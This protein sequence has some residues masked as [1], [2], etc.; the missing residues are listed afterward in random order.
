MSAQKWDAE[1]YEARH[2]F[3]WQYGAGLIDL[4]APKPGE[5]ILDVGCGTG[6]LT[7]QIAD[8]GAS[9]VGI[10]SALEMIGQ[11]RQNYP[12]LAFALC[13]CTQMK[14]C[15]EFDAIFSN[16]A[17]HWVL[18]A[19]VAVRCMAKALRPGGRLVAEFGGHGNIQTIETAIMHVLAGYLADAVPESRTFFPTMAQ[20]AA[21][22]EVNGFEVRLAQLYD[23]PTPLEGADGMQNWIRQFKWYYFA[24]LP[25][26]KQLE[27]LN[28][29]VSELRP[30]LHSEA[31]WTADYRRLRVVAVKR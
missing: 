2:S 10:D 6:Q 27:A 29:V 11:A 21:L 24:P 15:D 16:A 23:R 3:V 5:R 14:Y 26:S 13:D 12:Q 17:L 19:E 31:G 20:Y 30:L 22:L 9:V 1:L 28:E 7:K 25:A 8:A 4:L 18:Q